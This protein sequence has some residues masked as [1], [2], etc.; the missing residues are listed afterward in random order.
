MKEKK[1][2][3]TMNENK[4]STSKSIIEESINAQ[5]NR[6]KKID[7]MQE[8]FKSIN[9]DINNQILKLSNSIKSQKVNNIFKELYEKN[10]KAYNKVKNTLCTERI[11]KENKLK[12]LYSEK[13]KEKEDD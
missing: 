1:I 7:S 13:N 8:D 12:E 3:N 4:K 6:I 9:K 2:D 5:K 11:E 10:N